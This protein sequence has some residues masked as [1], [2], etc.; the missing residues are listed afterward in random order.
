MRVPARRDAH[1]QRATDA[2]LSLPFVRVRAKRARGLPPLVVLAGGPGGMAVRAFETYLYPWVDA[3]AEHCDVITFDQRGANG[4]QP[5]LTNPFAL[6]LSRTEPVSRAQF[7]VQSQANAGRLGEF[8]REHE[9]D[10]A[11][12]NTIESAHD[13]NDLRQALGID[14]INLHGASYDTHLGLAVLRQHPDMVRRAILCIVEG[15]N[16][17][18]KLPANTDA[19]FAHVSALAA[20]DAG[21]AGAF[22][23]LLGELRSILDEYH[24]QPQMLTMNAPRGERVDVPVGKFELQM[25][26]GAALGS[27]AAIAELPGML[28]AFQRRE[29]ARYERSL[30]RLRFGP[31]T[32]AMMLAM[33]YASGATAARSAL[34]E[35]QRASALLDDTFNLP[36]PFVGEQLGVADLG[37]DFRA[38]IVSSVPTLFCSGTLDGRT[39]IANAEAAM[40]GFGQAQHVIVEGTSHEVPEVLWPTQAA[41]LAAE[42]LPLGA[43]QREFVFSQ[44]QV[45]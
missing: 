26:L 40:A 27:V 38:P 1:G 34:I 41:F 17:T 45:K 13:V 25:L 31:G 30:A 44:P 21:L 39:P 16:D 32:D 22:P 3:L 6:D 14:Q 5:K 4:A 35:S 18:H 9:V 19:H 20:V 12:F 28:R 24:V 8:W 2:L 7:I 29:L 23:D 42:E 15:L 11:A 36:I 33:D 37:D 10:L 43:L